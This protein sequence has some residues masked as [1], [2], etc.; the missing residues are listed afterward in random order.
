MKALLIISLFLFSQLAICS[1]E[2]D[3]KCSLKATIVSEILKKLKVEVP[4]EQK[5]Q[6]ENVVEDIYSS[7]SETTQVSIKR[8][9]VI[10]TSKSKPTEQLSSEVPQIQDEVVTRVVT[11]EVKITTTSGK[12]PEPK[13]LSAEDG[14]SSQRSQISSKDK[15]SK[16][17]VK[18]TRTLDR[19]FQFS[20]IDVSNQ[21]D[22]SVL[23]QI[24]ITL[25][26]NPSQLK[27]IDLIFDSCSDNISSCRRFN[28]LIGNA[29]DEVLEKMESNQDFIDLISTFIDGDAEIDLN[30]V[31]KSIGIDIPLPPG[32]SSKISLDA[33]LLENLIKHFGDQSAVTAKIRDSQIIKERDDYIAFIDRLSSKA[34]NY[35]SKLALEKIKDL[36]YPRQTIFPADGSRRGLEIQSPLA[37]SIY[38]RL[39]KISSNFCNNDVSKTSRKSLMATRSR[40]AYFFEKLIDKKEF[41]DLYLTDELIDDN[42]LIRFIKE[43]DFHVMRE[44]YLKEGVRKFKATEFPGEAF[45]KRLTQI[46]SEFDQSILDNLML[47]EQTISLILDNYTNPYFGKLDSISMGSLSDSSMLDS[48]NELLD[49]YDEL[50]TTVPQLGGMLRKR[51]QSRFGL[52]DLKSDFLPIVKSKSSSD[53]SSES[54]RL[55][56]AQFEGIPS[57]FQDDFRKVV[58]GQVVNEDI[59]ALERSV[60]Q[61]PNSPMR[62]STRM[63]ETKIPRGLKKAKK[64]SGLSSMPQRAV[65]F[66]ISI[67]GRESVPA[68]VCIDR[69]TGTYE[70]CDSRGKWIKEVSFFLTEIPKTTDSSKSHDC[71]N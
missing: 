20:R 30:T 71:L 24:G 45:M 33:S 27:L 39:S 66:F 61:A 63:N 57:E 34:P 49:F 51:I 11:E 37:Q 4:P 43:G 2:D 55:I 16:R 68:M 25:D 15:R 19:E 26:A 60:R 59:F 44:V 29:S 8:T 36:T 6:L 46:D 3:K 31:F 9:E 42:D 65:D 17:K 58:T 32:D 69:K 47:D 12:S 7:L 13:V 5:E 38:D 52:V 28:Q 22:L 54:I 18:G 1:D 62:T 41:R 50:S 48:A 23:S 67:H 70:V 53:L 40:C 10:V 14:T 21:D 56:Q 64:C 35:E